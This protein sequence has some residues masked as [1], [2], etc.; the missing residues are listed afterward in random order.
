MAEGALSV[1]VEMPDVQVDVQPADVR[2]EI[3]EGAVQ[4]TV[5]PSDV[6]VEIETPRMDVNI[7]AR[8]GDIPAT[9]VNVSPTPVEIVNEVNLQSPDKVVTFDRDHDGNIIQA[10]TESA[11]ETE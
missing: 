9:V 11:E 4:V 10:T 1:S 3:A 8:A 6:N 7:E 2:T 5:E